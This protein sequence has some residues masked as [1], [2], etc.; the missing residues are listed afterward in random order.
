[1]KKNNNKLQIFDPARKKVVALSPEEIVRQ[2]I[3]KK[4]KY[5]FG[6]SENHLRVEKK[7]PKGSLKRPDIVV[8]NK[9]LKPILL[10]ECK[11]EKVRLSYKELTQILDYNRSFNA[12][13]IWL[14]N[15]HIN[16]CARVFSKNYQIISY[17]EFVDLVNRE[18][19]CIEKE[20]SI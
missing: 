12:Q 14:T 15:G 19:N 11:S 1:M 17:R 13:F 4:L 8:F 2:K 6:I 20:D 3:I 16:Y 7:N 9:D 10:I 18:Y 5:D